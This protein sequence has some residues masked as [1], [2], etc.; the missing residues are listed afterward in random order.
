MRSPP[1]GLPMPP[2]S[3]WAGYCHTD[4]EYLELGR[5][6]RAGMMKLLA[7]AGFTEQPGQRVLELGCAAERILRHFAAAARDSEYWGVD[8]S[9][10]H[11]AWCQRHLSPP[12][13]FST[14][15]TYPHLPFEDR[16]FDLIYA[17][18]VFTHI[19]DLEDMWLLEVRRILKPGALAFITIHDNRT[20]EILRNAT[21]ES[22]LFDTG[23]HRELVDYANRHDLPATGFGTFV[24]SR[25]PGNTQ[26]FHDNDYVRAVWGRYF[27]IVSM[28]SEA[29]AYQA[30]VILRKP[31]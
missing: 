4:A 9:A 7:A 14:C 23:I 12:F 10:E 13:R 20:I 29:T 3:L 31:M 11:I 2:Q 17:S 25:Q 8:I 22:W 1:D 5:V 26:V 15:T 28:T 30:A 18:S 24:T 19:G 21:N 27:D 6:H 16:S